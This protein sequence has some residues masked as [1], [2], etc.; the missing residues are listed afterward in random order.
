MVNVS[1]HSK[2]DSRNYSA[3]N[4]KHYLEIF[5]KLE[6]HSRT[7][8]PSFG[9][10]HS[11]RGALNSRSIEKGHWSHNRNKLRSEDGQSFKEDVQHMT[12][13]AVIVVNGF[14]YSSTGLGT[15]KFGNKRYSI[16]SSQ[17]NHKPK[18]IRLRRKV[19]RYRNHREE[20]TYYSEEEYKR[21]E[22]HVDTT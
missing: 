3:R 6:L 15:K 9:T 10:K 12:S 20:E 22:I 8:E 14:K 19:T 17:I 13:A 11:T 5:R 2:D 1:Q 16:G 4:F 18:P 21:L 7:S